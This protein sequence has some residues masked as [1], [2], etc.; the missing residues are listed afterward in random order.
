MNDV[1]GVRMVWC[2]QPASWWVAVTCVSL[3]RQ[4]AGPATAHLAQHS[5]DRIPGCG[6]VVA[7]AR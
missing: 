6:A 1:D 3:A 2:E 5:N 4:L 7:A